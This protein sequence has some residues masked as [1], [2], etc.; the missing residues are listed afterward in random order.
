M[1]LKANAELTALTQMTNRELTEYQKLWREKN[2]L[3][4]SQ[5]IYE[6]KG[7]RA[8]TNKEI[9]GLANDLSKLFAADSGAEGMAAMA[10]G[11]NAGV[12]E[13]VNQVPT[14][15]SQII[16]A[17]ADQKTGFMEQDKADNQY[18]SL[19]MTNMEKQIA[20]WECFMR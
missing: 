17:F 8:D 11:M 19:G 1:G 7:L 10:E 14:I 3:A 6:L 12:D 13:A 9:Q 4:R 5:A 18:I 20:A 16:N 2:A 15:V